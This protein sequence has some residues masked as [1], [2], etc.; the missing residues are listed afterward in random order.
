MHNSN[1]TTAC[2]SL[3][4]LCVKAMNKKSKQK[5]NLNPK[6]V[7]RAIYGSS[8]GKSGQFER[9]LKTTSSTVFLTHSPTSIKVEGQI[10]PGH[11]SKKEMQK[12]RSDLTEILFQ[13]LE[14]L[15]AKALQIKGR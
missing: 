5:W 2:L 4:T 6:E 7:T 8:S 11:Y 10:P 9:K 13:E 3:R 12:K 15:V 1:T 14:K